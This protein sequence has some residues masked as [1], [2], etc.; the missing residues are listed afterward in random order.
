MIVPKSVSHARIEVDVFVN[1]GKK[2]KLQPK[3]LQ[4]AVQEIVLEKIESEWKG[5][6]LTAVSKPTTGHPPEKE[7]V[8]GS[9]E[10]ILGVPIEQ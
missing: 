6:R 7:L 10:D 1:A 2:G 9:I 4:K 3:V 8:R 5:L